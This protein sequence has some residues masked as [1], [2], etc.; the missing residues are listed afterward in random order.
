MLN[1]A[2]AF[3]DWV[4]RSPQSGSEPI[5]VPGEWEEAS[6]AQREGNL[7]GASSWRQIC[8]AATQMGI[9]DEKLAAFRAL[10]S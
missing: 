9:S 4:R 8:L 2:Q 10:A 6:R 7:L 5:Q 1:E 3:L